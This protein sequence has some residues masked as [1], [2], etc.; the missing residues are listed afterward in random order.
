MTLDRSKT[1]L[2]S[3][4]EA[5]TCALRV[6]AYVMG[7]PDLASRFLA[8]TG[9]TPSD[10]RAELEKPGTLAAVLDFLLGFEPDLVRFAEASD[11]DPQWIERCRAMLGTPLPR[12]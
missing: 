5:E 11:V 9:I 2:P 3:L 7:E 4:E 1:A 6:V 10:L 8:L 12:H